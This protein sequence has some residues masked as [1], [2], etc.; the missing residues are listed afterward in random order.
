[1]LIVDVPFKHLF[2]LFL[3]SVHCII[4]SKIEVMF[5][6]DETKSAQVFCFFCIGY[7]WQPLVEWMGSS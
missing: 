6:R 5:L 4:S 1:M 7:P 3:V 2:L